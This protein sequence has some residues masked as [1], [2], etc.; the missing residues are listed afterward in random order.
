MFRNAAA[1]GVLDPH[2]GAVPTKIAEWARQHVKSALSGSGIQLDGAEPWDP[3]ILEPKALV[4]VLVRG[5]LGGGEAYADGEW[6][7]DSLDELVFRLLKSDIDENWD[8]R[9]GLSLHAV[10]AKLLNRQARSLARQNVHAYYDVGNDLYE[11]MLGRSMAYSCGYWRSAATL[12]EAQDAKH[13]LICRK[14]QLRPGI[15]ILDVGCG[16]GAFAKFAAQHYGAI[17]TGVTLSA[18]QAEFALQFC[19][20]LPVEIRRQDYREMSEQYDRIVSMGMFEFVGPA[21]YKTYFRCMRNALTDDGLF[22]LQTIGGLQSASS[23]DRWIARSIFP[24]AVLPSAS[25]IADAFEGVFVAEDWHN[26]GAHYD[27][28]LMAWHANFEAAWPRFVDRYGQRF[29]RIW[30]YYLLSSAGSF[31]ASRNQLWQVVFSKRGASPDY[32]RPLL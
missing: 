5:T 4:R 27:K 17:V 32:Q 30:R 11:A 12:D 13:D 2:T 3:Q 23:M 9:P 10:L 19:A 8:S 29:R 21:N 28:T 20:G 25:Q 31:R 14:L 1:T 6:E 15:R 18:A 26:L 24:N 7:C 16:W 22:F